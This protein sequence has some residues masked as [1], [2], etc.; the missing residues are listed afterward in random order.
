MPIATMFNS[1]PSQFL[2]ILEAEK[3]NLVTVSL[4]IPSDVKV[5]LGRKLTDAFSSDN[6]TEAA[7]AW[8]VERSLVIHETLEQHLIPAGVKWIRE[9]LRDEVEDLLANACGEKLRMVS[10]SEVSV[11]ASVC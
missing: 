3:K 10:S 1:A 9:V 11:I 2:H 8:N 6:F 5:D 7:K 4:T